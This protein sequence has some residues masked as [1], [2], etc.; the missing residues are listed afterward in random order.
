M[1]KTLPTNSFPRLFR[2]KLTL[3]KTDDTFLNME[4]WGKGYVFANGKNL[5][6]YWKKG[7]Q[8]RLYLP[9]VWLKK[10]INEIVIID[11]LNSSPQSIKG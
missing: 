11:L 8:K 5:G 9:G 2:Y 6:R 7:P 1:N 4:N 3:E 10:G